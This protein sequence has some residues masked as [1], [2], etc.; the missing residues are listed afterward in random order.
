MAADFTNTTPVAPA[1]YT[2]VT[3]QFDGAGNISAC[4]PTSI[5]TDANTFITSLMPGDVLVWNG[6]DWVNATSPSVELEVNGTP[7][8]VQSLLNLIQGTG[9]IIVDNGL[10][11]VTISAT[12]SA[13]PTGP[14]GATGSGATG[15]TGPTGATGGGGGSVTTQTN[16]AGS[17]SF[18]ATYQNTT[19]KPLFVGVGGNISSNGE[20]AAQSDAS[21]TPTTYVAINSSSIGGDVTAIFFIVLP[22]NYYTVANVT[23]LSS[24]AYW[25]EWN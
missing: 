11:G 3:W 9:I 17:R 8:V 13:G 15:A 12:G 1:G 21:S 24:V 18:G 6:T 16:V 2:N 22:G 10:G 19:G 25:I 5:L 14:T 4:V 20:I 23:G 7:N